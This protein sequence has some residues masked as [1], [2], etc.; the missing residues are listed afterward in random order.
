MYTA[1]LVIHVLVAILLIIVILIQRGRGGGL[2]ESFSGV[3]SM[4]GTRT[5]QFLTRATTVFAIIFLFTS[6]SLALLAAR[7]SRSL[8][9]EEEI[10]PLQEGLAEDIQPVALE[11]A[12]EESGVPAEEFEMPAVEP[13]LPTDESEEPVV[14][15]DESVAQQGA[16]VEQVVQ[17][18]NTTE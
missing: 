5:S 4:F 15:S 7:Q 8:I 13:E 14:G 16:V 17:E 18:E 3:E 9:E 6:I 11:V 12:G 10:T 1:I 2:V